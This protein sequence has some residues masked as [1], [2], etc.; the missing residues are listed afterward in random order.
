MLH[1]YVLNP[2]NTSY[3]L[4]DLRENIKES[5][6]ISIQTYLPHL[7]CPINA[8]RILQILFKSTTVFDTTLHFLI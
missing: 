7:C 5:H 4:I 1:I 6:N 3:Q 2:T 8:E